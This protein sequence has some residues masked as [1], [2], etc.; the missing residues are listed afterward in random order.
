M[1]ARRRPRTVVASPVRVNDETAC[2]VLSVHHSRLV[3]GD[4]PAVALAAAISAVPPGAA[5][6]PLVCFGAGW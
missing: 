5:P 6:A 1:A 4:R 2:E 3:A